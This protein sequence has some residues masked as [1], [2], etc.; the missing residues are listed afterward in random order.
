MRKLLAILFS[1]SLFSARAQYHLPIPGWGYGVGAWQSLPMPGTRLTNEKW[2]L[3][4]SAGLSAGYVYANHSGVSYLTA[5][6]S[7]TLYHPL[8]PNVTAFGGVYAAPTVFS[9]N[10]YAP[11]PYNQFSGADF[12]RGL[13]IN[14]GI[15]GGLMYTN[16]AHTFSISGSVHV[17][18]GS[19]PVY[20][21]T[22]QSTNSK[23]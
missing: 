23:N 12:T 4:P 17:E 2:Q 22:R 1:L 21:P 11:S 14:A 15:M 6:L 10:L 20:S 18:R 13:G 16:D 8:T 19:Y 3:I 5:P 9:G 7:L